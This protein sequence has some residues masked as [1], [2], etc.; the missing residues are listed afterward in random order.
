LILVLVVAIGGLWLF[1]WRQKTKLQRKMDAIRAAGYPVTCAELDDW[2]SI[3]D[4]V[5]NAANVIL[6]AISYYREP[7]RPELV[8]V[9]GQAELPGR[10]EALSEE[11]EEA[12]A[13]Y[14]ASCREALELVGEASGIEHSRYPIDLSAGFDTLM[15]YL[16]NVREMARLLK[17]DAVMH[18]EA[19]EA[20]Q[21]VESV[22]SLF[23]VARS[24]S[25]EPV[26]VSQLVR[27][28]CQGLGVSAIERIVNRA[29]L[30][31]KQLG[32]LSRFIA[33]AENNS[34]FVRAAA[35][36]RCGIL[37]ILRD[38]G[39]MD[40]QVFGSPRI[41]G[42]LLSVYKAAGLTHKGA[43]VYLDFA[44]EF[45]QAN[46]LAEHK[47][48]AAVAAI[49]AKLEETSGVQAMM[50]RLLV[51]AYGRVVALDLRIIARLRAVRAGLA[52][53]R[54]RLATGELAETLGELVPTYLDAV[55]KDPFDG[56][57]LRYKMLEKGYVVYSVGEDGNDDG[58]Q[59]MDEENKD[60]WDVTFIVE[61]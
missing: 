2:Y 36:E 23:G 54:Y 26:I 4:G 60:N 28:S 40:T 20:G 48:P 51:P 39:K 44:D 56:W 61:R 12:A 55:P 42:V 13:E 1:R 59:E 58:G 31:G 19:N 18:A 37:D 45:L 47:R 21:A 22:A 38:P 57:E 46:K 25:Q 11:A 32:E 29:E 24:L 9:V 17:L 43:M 30:D 34:G 49:Q 50:V 53:E 27:L 35:G 5:D 14:L 3:P 16:R 8:P 33:G 7:N 10:T 52:I 15:P 41:M 6:D